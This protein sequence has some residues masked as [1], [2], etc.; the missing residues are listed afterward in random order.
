MP[1]GRAAFLSHETF[2]RYKWVGDNTRPGEAF[3][4]AQHPSFYFPFHLKNPTPL[5]VMRDSGY[6]PAFQVDAVV[7]ALEK[8]P[9]NIVVWDGNW[10]KPSEARTPGDSLA[11]LWQFIQ[12]NYV[13]EVEYPVFGDYTQ[14]SAHEIEFWRKKGSTSDN[15]DVSVPF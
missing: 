1:A 11:P 9:P 14:S 3:F 2:E 8:D 5:S 4:E 15:R 13:L 6:T 12:T 7:A 10:S